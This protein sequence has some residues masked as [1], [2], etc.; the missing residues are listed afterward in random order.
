MCSV[1]LIIMAPKSNT[2]QCP[3]VIIEDFTI[4]SIEKLANFTELLTS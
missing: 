4:W 3:G 1:E 2:D